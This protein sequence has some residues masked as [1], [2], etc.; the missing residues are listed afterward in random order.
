MRQLKS[1]LFKLLWNHANF[2]DKKM[3]KII[4]NSFHLTSTFPKIIDYLY[5]EFITSIK[6]KKQDSL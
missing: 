5:G 1:K 6:R 4:A 2:D 3:K